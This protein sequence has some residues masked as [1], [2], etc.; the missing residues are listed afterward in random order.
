MRIIDPELL[1][2]VA[3]GPACEWCNTA[4]LPGQIVDAHHV[5]KRGSGGRIDV[6][7][8]LMTV[9]RFPCHSQLDTKAGRERCLQ[10]VAK[11]EGCEPSDVE[12]VVKFFRDLPKGADPT[13]Y[14]NWQMSYAA[15]KLKWQAIDAMPD[16]SPAPS[17]VTKRNPRKSALKA[18]AK[19]YRVKRYQ[20]AKA[21]KA[22]V[23]R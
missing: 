6:A 13:N 22:K 11:R 10:I 16:Q 17:P 15:L 2:R 23:K 3:H 8:N 20:D 21:F 19:A 7:C 14:S 4:I 5:C 18:R 12:A 1:K 9:H